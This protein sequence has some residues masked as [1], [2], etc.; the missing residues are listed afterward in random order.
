MQSNK[1]NNVVRN[2]LSSISHKKLRR[3]TSRKNKVKWCM[4]TANSKNVN[5][6]GVSTSFSFTVW[7][8]IGQNNTGHGMYSAWIA[9]HIQANPQ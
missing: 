1:V 7:S 3:N 4:A 2:V 9:K 5:R 8:E 6:S